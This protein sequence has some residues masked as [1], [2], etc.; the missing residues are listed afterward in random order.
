MTVAL[1]ADRGAFCL[2]RLCLR[3]FEGVRGD[4]DLD[5]SDLRE[6]CDPC[7][8]FAEDLDEGDV[9]DP[10]R[11]PE[12]A[13]PAGESHCVFAPVSVTFGRNMAVGQS[14]GFYIELHRDSALIEGV[15]E[16]LDESDC[17]Y[18]F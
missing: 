12:D 18:F 2:R 7:G 14:V 8:P 13:G 15:N 3:D 9:R 6:L 4:L 5:L 1:V 11:D 16:V 17:I 10:K